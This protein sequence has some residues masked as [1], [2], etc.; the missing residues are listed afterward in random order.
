[1][2]LYLITF[3][4]FGVIGFVVTCNAIILYIYDFYKWVKQNGVA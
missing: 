1:M 2:I 3:I 4:M